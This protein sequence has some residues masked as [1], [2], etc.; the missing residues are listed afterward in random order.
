[1]VGATRQTDK[2]HQKCNCCI[3]YKGLRQHRG[4]SDYFRREVSG[5]ALQ[6]DMIIKLSF[7]E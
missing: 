2:H 7:E 3:V 6:E 1:M 5:K 4:E